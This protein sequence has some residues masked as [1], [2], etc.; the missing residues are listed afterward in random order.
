MHA[1]GKNSGI[2]DADGTQDPVGTSQLDDRNDGSVIK[3]DDAAQ[4]M[5]GQQLKAVYGEIVRQPIP[6]QFL[7]LL[8]ELERK[9]NG[10]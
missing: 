7:K 9:E 4:Q 6:D 8:N 10:Q 3:L 2:P 5:I 1:N